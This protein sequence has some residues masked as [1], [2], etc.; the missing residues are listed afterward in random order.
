M[1]EMSENDKGPAVTLLVICSMLIVGLVLYE[2]ALR[3]AKHDLKKLKI[4]AVSVGHA[5]WAAQPDG[6]TKFEWLATATAEVDK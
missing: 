3:D 6:S 5:R 4:E 2:A 1:S